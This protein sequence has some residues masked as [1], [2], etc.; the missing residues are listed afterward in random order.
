MP[1]R[2]LPVFASFRLRQGFP[3]RDR[4]PGPVSQQGFLVSPHGSQATGSFLVV[5]D[6]CHSRGAGSNKIYT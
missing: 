6:S 1:E 4:V 3:G 2:L 5:T